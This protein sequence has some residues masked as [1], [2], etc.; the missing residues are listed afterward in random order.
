MSTL[1]EGR[2]ALVTGGAAGLGRA[3]ALRLA[4]DGAAV[5]LLDVADAT[6]TCEEIVERG[7]RA[8]SLSCDVSEPDAVEVAT[9]AAV[10]AFGRID[11]AVNNAGTYPKMPFDRM[12]P[13]AW[14]K[15]IDV[16]LTGTYLVCRAVLPIMAEHRYGRI[17]NVASRTVWVP[18]LGYA[19]YTAAKAGVIGLTRA[20]ATEYG[21][22]GITVNAVA[23]GI[24]RTQGS[25]RE[26]D[27]D[28]ILAQA[29]RQAIK[30][31]AEPDDVVGTVSFLTSD[32]AAFVT[33]QTIVVDGGLV[34]L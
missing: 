30:R 24:V 32:D 34:R 7:G 13:A 16:N 14:A 2:V 28:H 20:L 9:R 21:E 17:V 4:R 8:L 26:L 12:T 1:K 31:V 22:L 10:E 18:S 27:A 25:E 6:G 11:I 19:A 23:P 33:G 15:T 29:Q 5:A 3:Y